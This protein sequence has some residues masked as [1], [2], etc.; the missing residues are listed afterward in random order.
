MVFL[1]QIDV[2]AAR[3][4]LSVVASLAPKRFLSPPAWQIRGTGADVQLAAFYVRCYHNTHPSGGLFYARAPTGLVIPSEPRNF[5]VGIY[6]YYF[7][8]CPSQSNYLP[9]FSEGDASSSRWRQLQP[10]PCVCDPYLYHPFC[11]L[12]NPASPVVV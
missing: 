8:G 9:T 6:P 2:R 4:F 5:V 1:G 7:L 3:E 10:G 11:M 12:A